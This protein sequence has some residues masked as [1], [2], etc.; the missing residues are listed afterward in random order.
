MFTIDK[1]KE[2]ELYYISDYPL[3]KSLICS[4]TYIGICDDTLH[5]CIGKSIEFILKIDSIIHIDGNY[6]QFRIIK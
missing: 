1:L 2:G 4:A 5:F 6:I 3:K